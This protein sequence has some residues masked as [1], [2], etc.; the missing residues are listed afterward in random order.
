MRLH[1]S[2]AFSGAWRTSL[3]RPAFQEICCETM[4]LVCSGPH[5]QYQRE[6]SSS[7]SHHFSRPE[8]PGMQ[9][10]LAIPG[11]GLSHR[12]FIVP[13]STDHEQRMRL[14][15]GAITKPPVPPCPSKMALCFALIND[16]LS[17]S[18]SGFSGALIT[19]GVSLFSP[20]L[21]H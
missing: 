3:Y 12:R 2:T 15:S 13:A 20:K 8:Q 7:S 21:S 5:G 6:F 19:H 9:S 1:V 17:R 4:S 10:S 18:L 11:G 16:A 14:Y